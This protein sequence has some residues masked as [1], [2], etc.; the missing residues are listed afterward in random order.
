MSVDN[1]DAPPTKEVDKESD[2]AIEPEQPFR[3]YLKPEVTYKIISTRWGL[4]TALGGF[5]YCYHFTWTVAGVDNYCDTTRNYQCTKDIA[6]G[7]DSSAI[8]DLGIALVAIFHM[9]EW[10]R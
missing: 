7:D 9:V 1:P 2:E 6:A 3:Y 4:F 5:C 8:Y 10:L